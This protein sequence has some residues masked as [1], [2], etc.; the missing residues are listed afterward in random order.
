MAGLYLHIP[1]CQSRCVYCGFFSTTSLAMRQRYTDALCREMSL[2][3]WAHGSVDT[4]YLGGGTPSQ[5]L[6]EQLQQLFA[7]IYNIYNVSDQAEVTM[8]CNP[9]DLTPAFAEAL[10]RLPVNR[11][12]MGAQTFSDSRLRFLRRRHRASQVSQAVALLRDTGIANI[13]IDLMYGFPGETLAE[14]HCDIDAALALGAD[15]LSAYA[16]TY[17]E[18]TPLCSMLQKG[19]VSELDEELQRQMY[20]DL[21][22]RLEAAGYEHYELSNFARPGRRSRHNSGYWNHTPYVGLGAGAHSFDGSRRQWNVADLTAYVEATEHGSVPAEG[23]TLDADT[24]Y[25]EMVMTRLRTAD[26]LPLR[27]LT[28][29]RRAYCLAQARRFIDGGLLTLHDDVLRLSRQGLF[30][31]DMVMADLMASIP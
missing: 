11:V 13:S 10:R 12:S 9:D 19:Q 4:V 6:P 16:L 17:E 2:R 18:D 3:P 15:H 26:G 5:L 1:F 14:W 27:L 25:D 23:E 28:A 31:S 30:V 8:E 22:D 29:E 21:K 7:Y 24:L 20:Y